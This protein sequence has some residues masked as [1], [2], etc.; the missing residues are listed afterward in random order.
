MM[1]QQSEATRLNKDVGQMRTLRCTMVTTLL[2]M[3]LTAEQQAR[4]EVAIAKQQSSRKCP[5]SH[6]LRAMVGLSCS[7]MR[8]LGIA[9]YFFYS[10][11]PIRSAKPLTAWSGAATIFETSEVAEWVKQKASG[12]PA[13][14]ANCFAW[15]VT[16]SPE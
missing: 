8:A 3:C 6:R 4:L 5:C 12:I 14:L 9:P 11:N 10:K 7:P 16:L 1:T 2:S 15:H 13:R